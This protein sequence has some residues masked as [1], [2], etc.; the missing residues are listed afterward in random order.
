MIV[1]L[2]LYDRDGF[3]HKKMVRPTEW[4]SIIYLWK[5]R[6]NKIEATLAR[7]ITKGREGPWSFQIDNFGEMVYN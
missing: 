6:L 5:Q 1:V 4:I 3:L 2:S 7:H